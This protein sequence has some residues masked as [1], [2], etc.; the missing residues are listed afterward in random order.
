M[1]SHAHDSTERIAVGP[2]TV[3]VLRLTLEAE[4]PL[5]LE[6]ETGVGKS[7]LVEQAAA[8]LGLEFRALDL[9]LL[10]PPDLIGLPV[11]VNGR[12]TYAPPEHLPTEGE[13]I[14]LLEELNRADP[15]M[16]APA[17]QLLTARRLNQYV[18]PRG[19]TVMAAVNPEDGDYHVHRLDPALRDRFLVLRSEADRAAWLAWAAEEGIH[20]AVV[21][22][23]RHQPHVFRDVSPRTWEKVS[24]IL[25]VPEERTDAAS[26]VD[27]LRCLLPPEWSEILLHGLSEPDPPSRLLDPRDLLVAYSTDPLL[28]GLVATYKGLGRT[29]ALDALA[30]EV[31]RLVRD[32]RLRELAEAGA[33]RVEAFEAFADDL[34]GD[35]G[36]RLRRTLAANPAS[37]VT[38]EV[39]PL[40]AYRGK[41]AND[42]R[43]LLEAWVEA[44]RWH[45]VGALMH[46]LAQHLRRLGGDD[47]AK[48]RRTKRWRVNLVG[49]AQLVEDALSKP[50]WET[51]A[52]LG[53]LRGMEVPS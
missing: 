16:H 14:L 31:E 48:L 5:L 7:A 39:A 53:L 6:G 4:I 19:W 3:A 1:K 22:V 45:R 17:L 29:D 51:L 9:S 43:G 52:E 37:A 46:A 18:L 27:A 8:D 36:D 32:R 24:R 23:V 40:A 41:G 25:R 20:P 34:P 10:E 44:R 35:L 15:I 13:G 30:E 50:L 47:L 49:L 26:R 42:V 33:F 12:T 38:S 28:P 2:R 11:I 21:Q